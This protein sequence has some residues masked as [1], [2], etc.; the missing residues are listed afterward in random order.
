MR[1][2]ISPS[3]RGWEVRGGGDRIDEFP[4]LAEAEQ[5]ARDLACELRQKGRPAS[6]WRRDLGGRLVAI[7]GQPEAP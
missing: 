5:A 3:D 1:L 4:T 2:V 7:E 6:V